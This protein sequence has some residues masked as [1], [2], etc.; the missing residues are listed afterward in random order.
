MMTFLL[1]S[2]S[3]PFNWGWDLLGMAG[4]RWHIIWAPAIPW[5]QVTCV[6]IGFA[7]SM[8]ALYHCWLDEGSHSRRAVLGS[9]PLG[10]FLS[11]AAGAMICFFAG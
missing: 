11:S 2:L 1:Q 6:L 5:L 3:D 10:W 9:L 4:S 7:Y 8:Q